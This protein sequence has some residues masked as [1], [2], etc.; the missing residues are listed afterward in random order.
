MRRVAGVCAILI[1]WPLAVSALGVGFEELKLRDESRDRP[2]H[3][4]VWYPVE[5]ARRDISISYDLAFKGHARANATYL[6]QAAPR[7]LVMLSHGDRG[8]NVDQ[9]WLAEALALQGYV[10]AAVSHWMNTWRENTPEATIKVWDRPLD[11]RFA[12][13]E[14]A[15]HP[16]WHARIDFARVSAVG[17]S[18]GGYTALAL[19]G[20]IYSPRRMSE[21]CNA[22]SGARECRLGDGADLE[23]IDF[24]AARDSYRDPRIRAVVAMAP[25]LG[26]G[27]EPGSLSR[28]ATPT[29]IIA[30]RDDELLDYD[31]NA[32]AYADRIPGAQ[33]L[34]LPKGGH[35][36]FMPECTLMGKAV[37]WFHRFDICGRRAGMVADRPGQHEQIVKAITVFLHEEL[38]ARSA[39][40]STRRQ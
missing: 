18:A 33:I 31:L 11:I 5:D 9:S 37:T 36:V 32:K 14:L 21:Y 8:S 34:P 27:V 22:Q 39:V 15:A 28:I 35:F 19:A 13:D 30:A 23:S 29:L 2:V 7:P 4:K 20:A 40:T 1:A 17:H 16:A 26:P 12:L 38:A 10:V 3:L 24:T 6:E 25:A